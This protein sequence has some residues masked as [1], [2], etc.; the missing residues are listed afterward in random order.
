MA[1][2]FR[3]RIKLIPGVYINFSTSGISTTIGPKGMSFNIGPD[4]T[5]LNT[6]IPGTG[7]YNRVRITEKQNDHLGPTETKQIGDRLNILL[8]QSYDGSE[9]IKSQSINQLTSQGFNNLK[10]TIITAKKE[11]DEISSDLIN[12]AN[13]KTIIDTK[14]N[15]LQRSIFKFL[16]K[17]RIARLINE[18]E[19]LGAEINE[20]NEQLVLSS[21]ELNINNDE[22]FESLFRNVEQAY[23]LLFSCKK[24]WDITTTKEINRIQ[25]RT[26]ANSEI[27]RV[28]SK[29]SLEHS[30]LI[31]TKRTPLKLHNRNGGDIYFYPGFI[32]IHE[33]AL[34]FGIL[35]YSELEIE[36]TTMKFI[37][38]D[39][40]PNDT[41]IL[42]YTW[43]KENKDGTPDKRFKDNYQIPV[44]KYGQI[45]FISKTGLME[46]FLFSNH[47]YS[48]LFFKSLEE[49]ISAIKTA[50]SLLKQF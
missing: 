9:Q 12:K 17:K 3:K 45:T 41:Q 6:G 39:S 20:L 33:Q 2:R 23:H 19:E 4:G 5:Y 26:S 29:V 15:K 34:D 27:N 24:I 40:V 36:F 31:A 49:Y 43:A 25:R 21:V 11:Y 47:D 38:T 18:S 1:W 46:R 22:T 30:E 8:E 50:N 28:D 14:N 42:N 13:Q 16:Y 35:D 7:L 10:Q 48:Q 44:T 37:E 32:I